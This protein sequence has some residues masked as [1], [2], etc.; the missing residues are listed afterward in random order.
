MPY[1]NRIKTLEE[2][3]RMLDEQISNITDSVK[4]GRLQE[5]KD[6]YNKELRLMNR[7]QWD[8]DHNSVDLGDDL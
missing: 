3:I 1:T 4:L 2:S 6:L 8:N 7:A 5:M